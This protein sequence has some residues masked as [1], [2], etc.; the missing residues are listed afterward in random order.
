MNLALQTA[1]HFEEFQR[2]QRPLKM[3]IVICQ[4]LGR[5][6]S[7][8]KPHTVAVGKNKGRVSENNCF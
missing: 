8:T 6:Q 7:R 5:P 2:P 4:K 1:Q 3:Q